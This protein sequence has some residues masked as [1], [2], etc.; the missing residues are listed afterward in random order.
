MKKKTTDRR[1]RGRPRVTYRMLPKSLADL[2]VRP[3]VVV[4]REISRATKDFTGRAFDYPEGTFDLD[5]E[6]DDAIPLKGMQD[7]VDA[8]V[9]AAFDAAVPRSVQRKLDHGKAMAVIVLVSSPAW[10]GPVS[11]FFRATFGS[12]WKQ[13]VRSGAGDAALGAFDGL[14][15][16]SRDLSQ[17]HCVVGVSADVSLLPRS[18]VAS[19]DLS[20]RI[21][22]PS[23]AVIGAAISRF[24]QRPVRSLQAGTGAGLD[25]DELIACFRPGT[26]PTRIAARIAA[27]SA[28]LCDLKQEVRS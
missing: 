18:L 16:P 7:A 15:D 27:A 26:G 20:I 4:K 19:V 8:I 1:S 14:C 23:T 22:A 5:P 11:S 24:T 28:A 10:V 13:H 3:T 17:G 6:E 9:R 21:P 25:L 2:H 12:R